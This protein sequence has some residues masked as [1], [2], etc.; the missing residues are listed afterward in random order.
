[1]QVIPVDTKDAPQVK[2]VKL[3]LLRKG[4][5]RLVF[6]LLETRNVIM[7]HMAPP[8]STSSQARRIQ[9]SRNDPKPLRSWNMPDGLQDLGFMD[10]NRVSQANRL[11]QVC[12]EVA[13]RCCRLKI[14]WSI[15][16]PTSSLMWITS[17]FRCLWEQLRTS[18]YFA[19]FHN[20]VYGGDRKKSATIWTSCQAL[21]GLACACN[22]D[23]A[24]VRKEWGRQ[25]DGS[26][27][28]SQE[29]AYP[30]GMCS[31][32]ASIVLQAAQACGKLQHSQTLQLGQGKARLTKAQ[33]GAERASQ[34]LFPRGH[35]AP[36]L[37][38]PFPHRVWQQVPENVDRSV[39]VP[40]K[41]LH[42]PLFPKGSTTLAVKQQDGA[43]WAQVGI[44]VSP[45][46]FLGLSSRSIHP[47]SQQPILPDFLARAV[48]RYCSLTAARLN[49]LRV[50]VLRSLLQRAQELRLQ[51]QDL[52]LGLEPHARHVL[53]GKRLL[54]FKEMLTSMNFGGSSLVSDIM[55]GFRIT[56]WLSDAS[57][58]PTKVVIPTLTAEDLWSA[59][60]ENNQRMWN[61]CRSSGNPQL[62]QALWLQTLKEC[63]AGW[64]TLHVGL[65]NPPSNSV[66]SRRF[67]VQ[68]Q[69]KVRPI[70]DFSVSQV[71]NTLGS[72]VEKIVVMP[73]SS[74]VSLSLAL[75]RGLK[76]RSA[77][78]QATARRKD[79]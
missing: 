17:P 45:E 24:H 58:R 38:D 72:V 62:D 51:E 78:A 1:M 68:Q 49:E 65:C 61:L 50:G 47:E 55:Q 77:G 48:H 11:Y 23:F 64:A 28:T 31:Q 43:W 14:W 59:R 40:G 54:L 60:V 32:F 2:I 74:T 75:Q 52:D 41:R 39:F 36:P 5:L 20:C 13:L 10:R 73:S 7:V 4:S 9:R 56:G 33:S 21:Q 76:A 16:N 3:N 66:L 79:V 12:Q 37:V 30:P 46:E 69:D 8:C 71:N 15:E 26:W 34:G 6:R 27:A 57:L 67:A 70:D 25:P 22:K 29:A 19:T 35:Q 53:K 42:S 63:K 44:P 18:V